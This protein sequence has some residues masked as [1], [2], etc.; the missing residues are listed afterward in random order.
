MRRL[1]SVTLFVASITLSATHAQGC[2]CAV[3]NVPK[4]FKQARAVFLGEVTDIAKPKTT[5]PDAS[6]PGRFFTITFTVEKSWKGVPLVDSEFKVLAAQG[7]YG[8]FAYPAVRKGE[9]YLVYADAAYRDRG[10]DSSWNIIT[11]C[12]RTSLV[13][14]TRRSRDSD[15]FADMKVLDA[16]T[17]LPSFT[18]DFKPTLRWKGLH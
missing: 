14:F 18:L 2:Y 15:P 17:A 16:I 9:R 7:N 13:D 3:G 11:V 10:E 4:A 5:D 6:L 12:N 1:I 8:C